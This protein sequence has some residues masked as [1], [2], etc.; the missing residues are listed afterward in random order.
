MKRRHFNQGILTLA[1]GGLA[2]NIKLANASARVAKTPSKLGPLKSDPNGVLDLPKDFSYEVISTL[3]RPM[4]DGLNVPDRADGM[5]CFALDDER[6]ALVRNHEISLPDADEHGLVLPTEFATNDKKKKQ[7]YDM[8]YGGDTNG[9]PLPGGTSHIIY[10]LKSKK[11]ENEFMSLIGTIRNCSGG[12]TPWQTW[13]SCEESTANQADGI[14]KAHGYVFEVP[15]NATGLV[16]G[17]PLREMGR[18]NHEAACVDPISGIVYLTED[19]HDSLFY[20]F[21]PKQKGN[22]AAGGKL[23]AL[24]II[25]EP[26][27]DTRNWHSESIK[28]ND[29]WPCEWLDMDDVE[30]PLDDLRQ[31]GH[32]QGA[33]LFARGEGIHF[34]DKEMYFCCTNGGEKKLGQIM[35]YVPSV[36]EGEE[37]ESKQ[38][39]ILSLFV[40][41]KDKVSFNYGDN[42]TI[43]PNGHLLVCEDQYTKTTNNHLKGVDQNGMLYDFAKVRWQTEPAGVCFSPDGSTLFVNLYSPTTTLAITGPWMSI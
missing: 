28:L 8:S 1:I 38:P 35:R 33:A 26:Q 23:Q 40:E 18:F 31:R 19:R 39:G 32:K 30:S 24:A 22:L 12:A 27:F 34:G 3:G 17:N 7:L 6:V 9:K 15:A 43:A 11:V 37:R 4:S 41:S 25:K 14:D 10:N 20:R 5:G 16:Q 21:I 13:L 2:T 29:K 42:I 36:F